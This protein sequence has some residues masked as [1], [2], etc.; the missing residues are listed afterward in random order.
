MR[1][2]CCG[3]DNRAESRFCTECGNALAID[4]VTPKGVASCTTPTP[5]QTHALFP[6]PLAE[7]FAAN[8]AGAPEVSRR[9]GA[10]WCKGWRRATTMLLTCA[11][12]FVYVTLGLYTHLRLIEIKPLPYRLLE[13]FGY[14]ERALGDALAGRDP[15]AIHQIGLA[16]LY[17]PPSLFVIEGF[18]HVSPPLLKASLFIS[19]NTLL[20]LLMI[21]GVARRYGYAPAAVWWWFPLGLA[22][23]P[24]LELLHVGQI[25]MITLF[26]VFLTIYWE[27]RPWVSG[28]TLSAA[29]MTKVTPSIVLGYLLV[30]RNLKALLGTAAGV[31]ILSGLAA[32]RYGT[33]LF[34][35]YVDAFRV[36]LHQ[37]PLGPNSQ[38]L[39]AKLVYCGWLF[40]L[41]VPSAQRL[42]TAY[43]VLAFIL[44][45]VMALRT[46]DCE[47][48]LI[49][50]LFGTALTPSVLWYHHYVFLLLP[51]FAWMGW[52]RLRAPV[53]GWCVAGL[54]IVQVDRY[55]TF[56][57][58]VHAFGHCSILAVLYSQTQEVFRARSL[59]S[60]RSKVGSL[61]TASFS[62]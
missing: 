23:A 17:P 2:A 19:T 44:S 25:N 27:T 39:V 35:S 42:L 53:V 15:Y 29:I 9:F 31:L 45:G 51:V 49:V 24:F 56:G 6:Q 48:F 57:F 62:R 55:L 18:A 4:P 40:E 11:V 21:A 8:V 46:R 3:H 54:F 20:L 14:Y 61:D 12:L 59:R 34:V 33:H 52:Q 1:C 13:D 38:S 16:Y 22:F 5:E 50:L 60:S 10:R 37:F 30:K 41:N 28:L 26:A 47:P 58:L 43:V 32:L 36:L 7:D